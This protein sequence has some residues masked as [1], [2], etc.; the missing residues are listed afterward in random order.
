MLIESKDSVLLMS[1]NH[2][3]EFYPRTFPD[4]A[5]KEMNEKLS[6]IT[7]LDSFL[8]IKFTMH[9]AAITPL[10]NISEYT[11]DAVV[12]YNDIN[13]K[14]D[15]RDINLL[16]NRRVRQGILVQLANEENYLL[17]KTVI[18]ELHSIANKPTFTD[19]RNIKFLG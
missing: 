14:L 16:Y 6:Q 10:S 9:I 12:L 15:Q 11:M 19:I 8:L 13:Y 1:H 2:M 3:L 18:N 5:I 7:S 17:V 4:Y